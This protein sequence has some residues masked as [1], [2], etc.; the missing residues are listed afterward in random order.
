MDDS[1]FK[2]NCIKMIKCCRLSRTVSL[3]TDD[4]K[5]V[6]ERHMLLSKD[7]DDV[8]FN[9]ELRGLFKQYLK[10]HYCDEL[11]TLY[12]IVYQYRQMSDEELK[13]EAER[14]Y[15]TYLDPT[16]DLYVNVE[17]QRVYHV[18]KQLNNGDVTT[19]DVFDSIQSYLRLSLISK[20]LEFVDSKEL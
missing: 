4:F 9:D 6:T 12:Q 2:Y 8:V 11:L 19:R 20:W 13:K 14:I 18:R 10:S 5:K 15:T 17:D 1:E 7:L 16:S 3:N